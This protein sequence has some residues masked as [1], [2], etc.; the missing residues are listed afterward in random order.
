MSIYE[1]NPYIVGY[2]ELVY[3]TYHEK[4]PEYRFLWD[5]YWN[6]HFL[7]DTLVLRVYF[8]KELILLGQFII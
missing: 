8:G 7:F 6:D 3:S 4:L 5:E 2:L 1:I